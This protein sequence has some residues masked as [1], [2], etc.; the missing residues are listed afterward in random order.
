MKKKIKDFHLKHASEYHYKLLKFN[1]MFYFKT[2][3]NWSLKYLNN[4]AS[5]EINYKTRA[6]NLG[7]LRTVADY[8]P[9]QRLN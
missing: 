3:K 8:L 2:L 9:D 1:K 4:M 7:K 5:K 6:E